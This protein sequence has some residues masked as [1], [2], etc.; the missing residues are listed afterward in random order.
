MAACPSDL[1]TSR[2]F[3]SGR[4]QQP[5]G[6]HRFTVSL[7]TGPRQESGPVMYGM[8]TLAGRTQ[9]TDRRN[10]HSK[11]NMDARYRFGIEEE[12]F[13]ADVSTHST[14]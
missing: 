3:A 11:D 1:L 4:P 14:H 2:P 7:G 6:F 5:I 13:L 10:F 9:S 12:Y 8:K